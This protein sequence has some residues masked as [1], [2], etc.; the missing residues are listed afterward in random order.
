MGLSQVGEGQR[1]RLAEGGRA[2]IKG[3]PTAD[4]TALPFICGQ[5]DDLQE[6]GGSSAQW[7]RH[8]DLSQ[9]FGNGHTAYITNPGAAV[10]G[11]KSGTNCRY[12]Q[13]CARF[14]C[15]WGIHRKTLNFCGLIIMTIFIPAS[16]YCT[17]QKQLFNN[18][19]LSLWTL[20]V[21]VHL[22]I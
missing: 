21:F 11:Y 17:C 15:F 1:M 14:M 4:P 18:V 5:R 16:L 13:L 12:L 20:F 10:L 8:H 9:D 7:N 3:R 2:V 22:Q 6:G 19:L